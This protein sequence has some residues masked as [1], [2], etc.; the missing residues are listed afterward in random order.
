MIGITATLALALCLRFATGAAVVRLDPA[1]APQ[2]IDIGERG[3]L[4]LTLELQA[5]WY[6]RQGP[7]AAW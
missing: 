5:G 2:F 3:A 4:A 6:G 7:G 1:E